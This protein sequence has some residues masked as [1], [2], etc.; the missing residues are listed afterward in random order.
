MINVHSILWWIRVEEKKK[1]KKIKVSCKTLKCIN[2]ITFLCVYKQCRLLVINNVYTVLDEIYPYC[3][4]ELLYI[5]IY[6]YIYKAYIL[7]FVIQ[8]QKAFHLVFN[9]KIFN[10]IDV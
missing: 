7:V 2:I 6:I 1:K 10:D 3:A 8:I 9:F 5:Y 4:K